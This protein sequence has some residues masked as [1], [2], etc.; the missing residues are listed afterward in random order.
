MD[1]KIS[2]S[3]FKLENYSSLILLPTNIPHVLLITFI[4][5]GKWNVWNGILDIL[6]DAMKVMNTFMYQRRI[7]Y[8]LHGAVDFLIVHYKGLYGWGGGGGGRGAWF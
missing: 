3:I 6:S 5:C 1:L 2:V 7:L 8:N 4:L